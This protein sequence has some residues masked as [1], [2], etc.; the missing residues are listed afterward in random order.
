[1]QHFQHLERIGD[2]F[3]SI[4]S[5]LLIVLLFSQNAISSITLNST[6][7]VEVVEQ[8][9][10]FEWTL[11]VEGTN[12]QPK[13]DFGKFQKI[14]GPSTSQQFSIINGKISQSISFTYILQAPNE[15]GRFSLP[16]AT[17]EIDGRK[18]QTEDAFIEVIQS[19]PSKPKHSTSDSKRNT[20]DTN[21]KN[22]WIEVKADKKTLYIGEKARVQYILY[23]QN[24]R[25]LNI[26][27]L[28]QGSGFSIEIA[29]EIKE[30]KIVQE[31]LNGKVLNSALIYD[32]WIIPTK[33]GTLTINPLKA[34]IEVIQQI[35]RPRDPFSIFNDPFSMFGQ[36]TSVPV[37]LTSPTLTFEVK[38]LPLLGK[39]NNA[40]IWVGEYNVQAKLTHSEIPVHQSTAIVVQVSG[41]GCASLLPPKLL[42]IQ[43]LEEYPVQQKVWG[44]ATQQKKEFTYPVVGR[45][46]NKVPIIFQPLAIFNPKTGTYKN[47]LQDT[48]WLN[49]LG[50]T[51]NPIV[52]TPQIPSLTNQ[53]EQIPIPKKIQEFDEVQFIP[54]GWALSGGVV[55]LGLGIQIISVIMGMFK[56][57]ISYQ[58]NIL[59]KNFL[60]LLEND[61]TNDLY[62][63]IEVSF[64]HLVNLY[65]QNK[66]KKVFHPDQID[67]NE[68]N[69][70]DLQF[71]RSIQKLWSDFRVYRYY[72]NEIA[73]DF[74]RNWKE[75]MI[76]ILK[77]NFTINDKINN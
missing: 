50:T 41:S 62:D 24:A 74:F 47:V 76:N 51:S 77:G 40:E 4:V 42:P 44:E 17:I 49:I 38:P 3:P 72:P 11:T 56:R 13:I 46:A 29:K 71:I 28:P 53:L 70:S 14:Q 18:Y 73:S 48:L 75:E 63:D 26:K 58:K 34:E 22:V 25:N 39:P 66:D 37:E 69:M 43:G 61:I 5:L 36:Y 60:E 33:T 64:V 35:N 54:Y 23:F 6:A 21:N 55:F 45:I 10:L 57:R 67:F 7:S 2:L 9:E 27:D 8:N 20:T 31:N 65:F 30:Y 15:I 19:T 68:Q 59:I 16:T 12:K 32:V 52:Y 1:M